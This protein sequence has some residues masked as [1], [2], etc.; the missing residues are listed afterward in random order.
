MKVTKQQV[1]EDL[2][3]ILGAEK[4]VTDQALLAEHDSDDGAYAKAF[5]LYEV[6]FP[7]CIVNV[8]SKEEIASV[9]RYCNEN[10]VAVIPRTGASAYEGLLS[11][12]T[13]DTIVLDA[14]AMNRIL[15]IDTYNMMVTCEC[16]V[17][18]QTL[19][20]LMNKQGYTTGHSPQ[21]L[22]LAQMGGLVATR[23]IGQFS[24]YYGCIEDLVCGL[25]AILPNGETVRIR[26]VPRRSTG[27]DLRHLLIGSEGAL[28]FI[29]E[30]T[31]KIFQYYPESFWRGGYIVKDMQTG[32]ETLRNIITAGYRPSVVRLYDKADYDY[33]YGTVEL[34]DSEAFLF[35]LAEGPAGIAKA[36]GEAVDS[37]VRAAG[38]RYIGTES[39][40]YWMIHR[41]DLCNS[42]KSPELRQ[43][44]RET[45]LYYCTTEIS[46][47]WSDIAVIYDNVIRRVTNE[48]ENLVMVGGHVSHSY[49]NG[50]NIYFVYTLLIPDPKD[51]RAAH[52]QVVDI[53][54]DEVLDTPTGGSAHHHGMGKMRVK[55]ADREHGSSYVL[56]KGIKK[57]MDPGGIMNP[58][59]LIKQ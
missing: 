52:Q 24:T 16:G 42:F 11:A 39:V 10:G 2:A 14:S 27:P 37:F 29:T 28:A 21:S 33:N 32:L 22:P 9:L 30:V 7:I 25:E 13:E 20:N 59:A 19:E 56:M 35:F 23:S 54:C 38:G 17:P 8:G 3:R 12:L 6:P 41:N 1:L 57:M 46:A 5:G 47:S 45:H 40:D 34:N 49:Q 48:V 15:N 26:N 55:F 51:Y 50:T 4:I 18:L 43:K 31:V 36:T 58:G 44:F 53:I